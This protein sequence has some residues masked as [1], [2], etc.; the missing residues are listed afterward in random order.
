MH[1]EPI[2]GIDLG[3]TNSCAAIVEDSGNVKLIPYKGGEYTIPSIFAIDDKGNELIGFEAKRQWQLNPRNTVY[4]AKRLV[5]VNY[6]SDVVGVMKK[7]VAYNMRAGAKNDVTLDVGKK[8]FTLQEISAKIL[9]KIRDVAA[10]YLKT[11]IKRAVVTV[12]AYFND[13]QRQ[14]VKDAGKLIDLEVVRII[15]EPTAAAL[16]YGVGKTLKEKVVIYDLGGGTFD[17]SIIEIRDRVFEVKATGG[18]VFLGGIDF[19][20]AIIHHVLKDFA[21]KTGI[22]LATDPVAM[23]RIK[24]L[25]ERT[26]IDLSAREEVPFN[27]PFITMT[28]Q[29][30]PLNIEMKFT[31]KMLEQLTNQLVDRTLQMVARVLVDSGLSTKDIDEVMLVGG[32]TRMPVVQ[33][34]LTKFFGKPPSKGVHPDEAV[35]IGAALYAHSLE[36]NTN[37]RIQLLDVI[38]MAIGLERGDGGFHVVF[39]RNA[40]IPN[41][42]QLLATTSIDNQTE[43]A[44]RIYQGDHDT[45]ARND[46]LGEFTFSGIM[47]AKAGT[48]NVEIIFDVSVEGIL[49]MRA[50][51]PA[52]GRE[53]KTTVRVTQS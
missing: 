30:Q 13:R 48:V 25:A 50:K 14:S 10:N 42:K 36:D 37:L 17:V 27:I 11:P 16:A 43:L 53:M 8:E 5:G 2:I 19:D 9:G 49:T 22:D 21:A 39:P 12:P 15:N 44:M 40:S 52:T 23:Q 35:A 7:S 46:L 20:N 33:D 4:G 24:D 32:Q 6:S 34:R 31:R 28:A 26:K 38:P 29:G 47:P 3:T 51:D 41:A 18:D 45:V 1:K